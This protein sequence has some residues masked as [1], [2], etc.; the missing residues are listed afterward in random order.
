MGLLDHL[1]WSCR[2][3]LLGPRRLRVRATEYSVRA[4]RAG[5][6]ERTLLGF[7]M[8]TGGLWE[9]ADP[10]N[11]ADIIA[12]SALRADQRGVT[13]G[14][15]ALLLV[16]GGRAARSRSRS[17]GKAGCVAA[18]LCRARGVPC[19][20]LRLSDR[21]SRLG[22]LTPL[23]RAVFWEISTIAQGTSPGRLGSG[24]EHTP[25]PQTRS[26]AGTPEAER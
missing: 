12:M 20:V 19:I 4:R 22:S 6:R 2:L 9:G 26:T 25:K 14:A 18:A 8:T 11:L 10:R 23:Y 5:D 7:V 17:R 15:A 16:C 3:P 24:A 21:L 13:K 1:T